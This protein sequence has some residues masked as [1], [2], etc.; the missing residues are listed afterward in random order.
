MKVSNWQQAIVGKP[1]QLIIIISTI[2]IMTI[3]ISPSMMLHH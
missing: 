3:N 1:R 2:L